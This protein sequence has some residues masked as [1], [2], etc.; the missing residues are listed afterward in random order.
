MSDAPISRVEA[1]VTVRAYLLC[2]FAAFGGIL[3]GYDSGYISGVLGMAYFKRE[4]G[5]P[6]DLGVD[7]TG[8]NIQT[9]QKSLVTSILS[10]GT[11]FGALFGGGFADWVG[12]RIAIITACLIFIGGVILQVASTSLGLLVA[13][14]IVAGF[15]VGIVSAV[16][17]LYMSEIAPKAV[18][19]AIV[20]GYQFAITL[21]I[22]LAACV[23]YSTQNR[24]DTGSYR[25]PIAIQMLWAIILASGLFFLPESPRFWVKKG[26]LD[27]AAA[28]LARVRGQPADSEYVVAEL[29]EIQANFEYEMQIASA[30]WADVLRGGWSN[31]AG[32]FRRI[33]L[34][35]FLQMMQQW[36]GVNFIFY[37]GT[38]FFQQSGI[39]NAFTI[40]VITNVVNVVTTPIAFWAVERLGRRFL[41]IAGACSMIVCEFIV[42]GVGTAL[43]GSKAAN[44]TL[45]VFVCLYIF[46]FATTWG[47]VAWVLIGEIYP[48]PI[49]AKGVAIATASNWLWNFV[50]GY[51]T[52]Y[53]VDKDEGNLGSKVFFVW[54]STCFLCLIF[55]Y[56]FVPETKGLS[57]EQVDRML[58]ETTPRNS[59]K[60]VP[61][62]T[63]ANQ[64]GMTDKTGGAA[65]HMEDVRRAS[66]GGAEKA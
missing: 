66:E 60:W 19:G 15:G 23:D 21:G 44:T 22:F 9:W 48:L 18:R 5:G 17:I 50:I 55:A 42:A 49:R 16:V 51:I 45:I 13:G 47:P 36:T 37:Y 39:K 14:R 35:F 28:A 59:A 2:A 57:L 24:N 62:N 65:T 26:E 12:R 34:G 20:S 4:F 6:V 1:P 3:F 53:I 52:P 8:Y 38:T 7:E 64:M 46:S 10:A 56:F 58:E 29:A 32:N 54:G 25:I 63:F 31:P 43:P 30:G 41:L 33:F 40:Q 61:H 11:F 27:K